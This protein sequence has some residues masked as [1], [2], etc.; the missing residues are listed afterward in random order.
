M[1]GRIMSARCEVSDPKARMTHTHDP[2]LVPQVIN[3]ATG[4]VVAS[5]YLNKMQPAISKL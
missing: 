5:A 4:S 2:D 3:K 1:G